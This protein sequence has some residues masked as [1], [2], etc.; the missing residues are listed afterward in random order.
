MKTPE[1]IAEEI[2]D[3]WQLRCRF[4]HTELFDLIAQAIQ[5]ERDQKIPWPSEDLIKL[6]GY[7]E[8]EPSYTEGFI[9]CFKWLKEYVEKKLSE[10]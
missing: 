7:N 8:Y 3:E 5:A 2:I 6:N 1:Q 10:K 4:T 9:D